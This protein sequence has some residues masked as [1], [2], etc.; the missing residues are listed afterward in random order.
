MSGD[1]PKGQRRGQKVVIGYPCGGSVTVP[2]HASC[3]RL[4]KYE[5]TKPDS[6]RLL[7]QMTHTSGLYVA[8][9]RTLLAQRFMEAAPEEA[10]W[11]LQIDTDIEFPHTLLETMVALAGTERKIVAANLP[12]GEGYPTSAFFWETP[13]RSTVCMRAFPRD[14]DLVECDA[15]A[16][17]V[18]LVHRT[19]FEDMAKRDGRSWF[20]H[21]Y[22]PESSEDTPLEE[23]NYR[24]I[25][26]DVAFCIRAQRAGHKIYVARVRGLRHYKA[27]ALSEDFDFDGVQEDQPTFGPG[28]GQLVEER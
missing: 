26:E 23:F 11:L 12:L 9:N 24:S 15:A 28:M 6:L 16:T 2:F 7:G 14:A 25:G 1:G 3:L 19:V 20:H 21:L 18:M 10:D 5:L 27:R 22:M 17:A 4:L 8:D 13:G